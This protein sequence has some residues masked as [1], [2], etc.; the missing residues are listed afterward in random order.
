MAVTVTCASSVAAG[1]SLA[2]SL[3]GTITS[4]LDVTQIEKVSI[5]ITNT[6]GQ[7]GPSNLPGTVLARNEIAFSAQTECA[8]PSSIS[9]SIPSGAAVG[10]YYVYFGYY[11]KHRYYDDPGWQQASWVYTRGG[12]TSAKP[13]SVT[14]AAPGTPSSI[15][16]PSSISGVQSVKVDWGTATGTITG[17]R[18]ERQMNGGTWTQIYQGT[19]LTYTDTSASTWNTVNYRVCAYNTAG[20]GSYRTGT[21]VAVTQSVIAFDSKLALSINLKTG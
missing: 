2:C 15:T 7:G 20:N 12:Y 10:T 1:S 14:L 19:A 6:D 3:S 4:W 18:L 11:G 9:V 13:V 8:P 16:F 5:E 21:Q 17:Y